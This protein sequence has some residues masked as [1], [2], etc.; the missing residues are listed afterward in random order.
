MPSCWLPPWSRPP[1]TTGLTCN[2]GRRWFAG[3][4]PWR[5]PIP[6]GINA[7]GPLHNLYGLLFLLHPALPRVLGAAV[8]LGALW[9]VTGH[10]LRAPRDARWRLGLLLAVT[11]NPFLWGWVAV[12]GSNDALAA[13]FLVFAAL[14][15]GRRASVT[16]GV[17]VALAALL[18]FYPLLVI[19]FVAC[20]RRRLDLPFA[21]TALGVFVVGMG[22]AATI[23]GAS[24]FAPLLFAAGREPSQLSLY[25]FLATSTLSP[26][27][28]VGI[29]AH[30]AQAL[31]AVVGLVVFV[32][33]VRRGGGQLD[34]LVLGLL[35]TLTAYQLGHFQFY[36]P[37]ALLIPLTIAA[38]DLAP[39]PARWLLI[40]VATVSL[41]ATCYLA[42]GGLIAPPWLAIRQ[43]AGLPTF[44]VEAV[45]LVA[46]L[47]AKV[48][49]LV[50]GRL[51]ARS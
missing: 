23:W 48:P 38:T 21:A 47:R 30:L 37:L 15:L 13:A 46:L 1:T 40:V 32:A 25:A 34:G 3:L 35:T 50:V 27:N 18:K 19:P 4:D 7:Y 51:A 2:N 17:C 41:F 36:L 29:P 39:V 11:L 45:A 9:P 22:L 24:I 12:F 14:A 42:F 43:N 20:D 8:W 49:S 28:G 31:F 5:T 6:L 10:I 16:A 44:F 26:L 33:H